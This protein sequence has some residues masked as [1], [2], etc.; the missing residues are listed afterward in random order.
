MSTITLEIN[1]KEARAA[2]AKLRERADY[3]RPALSQIGNA[4]VES[5]RLRN[6]IALRM[7]DA[8]VENYTKSHALG[9]E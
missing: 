3:L 7:E 1:D 2:L 8:R 4:L 9:F 5:T 6:S